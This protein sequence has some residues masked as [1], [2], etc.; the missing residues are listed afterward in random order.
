MPAYS[1]LKRAVQAFP[2]LRET[3]AAAFTWLPLPLSAWVYRAMRRWVFKDNAH[4]LP[5]MAAA[6]DALNRPGIK[7]RIDYLEF[8]V[9]RGTSVIAMNEL[10]K[11]RGMSLNTYAFDSFEGLPSAEGSFVS[12]DMAYG[13]QTFLRFVRK[14][15]VSLDH[16]RCIPGY[17][18]RSLTSEL[19]AELGLIQARPVI[20]HCDADLYVSARDMLNWMSTFAATGS[21]VIFDDWYAFDDQKRPQDHGE[22]KAFAE[23]PDRVN[24][25]PLA[26]TRGWNIAFV[27]G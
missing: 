19:K 15:G 6:L 23:W 9:A 13:Q 1:W 25:Q 11:A 4:R 12:G 2:G 3:L 24:W 5:V 21:V 16:L 27:R 26:D 14:A 17:F 10:A 7:S 18:D 22:Q 20:V 8:G